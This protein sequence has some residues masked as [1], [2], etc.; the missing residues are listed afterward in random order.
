MLLLLCTSF[1]PHAFAD[2]TE[3]INSFRIWHDKTEIFSVEAQMLGVE[4]TD[5]GPV[6]KLRTRKGKNVSVPY[7]HLSEADQKFSVE[8]YK[9]N[10]N[11]SIN[12]DSLPAVGDKV[13][14]F[15]G[16]RW[17]PGSIVEIDAEKFK[18]SYDGYSSSWDEWKTAEQLRWS[19]DR[20]VIPGGPSD[21]AS[22]KTTSVPKQPPME[23]TAAS[24]A[25]TKDIPAITIDN[26]PI[27]TTSTFP[28][29]LSAV[30]TLEYLKSQT[31]QG[32]L[33]VY[34][35]WLPDHVRAHFVS[36]EHRDHLAVLDQVNAKGVGLNKAYNSALRVFEKQEN[37]LL[38]SQLLRVVLSEGDLKLIED[39]YEPMTGLMKE[40]FNWLENIDSEIRSP[41]FESTLRQR[42]ER[43]GR[44]VAALFDV[45]PQADIDQF[46]KRITVNPSGGGGGSLVM[47]YPDGSRKVFALTQVD[48]RWMPKSLVET[49][50][51]IIEKQRAEVAEIKEL[52]RAQIE[53]RAQGAQL[54]QGIQDGFYL[55]LSEQLDVL[56]NSKTQGEF[57]ETLQKLLVIIQL[58]G[59]LQ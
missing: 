32:N 10:E 31:Q 56:A 18:F 38:Q 54:A 44:H 52:S 57:D 11:N 28:K 13:K 4:K 43:L 17:Y 40:G 51:L 3:S 26:R 19:D 50:E 30:E 27:E 20:P 33:Q 24:A 7:G 1:A 2:D 16:S 15:W 35:D 55:S 47:T 48:G 6:I 22:E 53:G 5:E 23:S 25:A 29:G 39:I 46:W 8:W 49:A 9:L 34:W 37:F 36:Q 12:V 59:N 41:R 14:V 45:L 42:S 21:P 58:G